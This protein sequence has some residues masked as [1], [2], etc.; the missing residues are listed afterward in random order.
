MRAGLAAGA[1]VHRWGVQ[2]HTWAHR[3]PAHLLHSR[4]RLAVECLELIVGLGLNVRRAMKLERS[5]VA[6]R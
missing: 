1:G 6:T 5:V 3:R 2:A 4:H